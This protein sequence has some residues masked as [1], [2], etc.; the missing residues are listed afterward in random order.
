MSPLKTEEGEI[1]YPVPTAQKPCKTWYKLFGDLNSNIRP[2][3]C[4]HGGPGVSHE[5]ISPM[6]DLA[7]LYHI[8][9]IL[10]DQLGTGRSTHLPEKMG[11]TSFWT[12]QLFLNE[13]DNLLAHFGIQNDYDLLGHSWGGMLG[14]RH[15]TLQPKGLNRLV[16]SSSPASMP[17]WV[18]AQNVL[19]LQLSREVQDTLTRHEREG[20]TES[21][22]YEGAVEVFYARFM[23]RVD[24]MPEEIQASFAGLKKDN[25][26][27]MTMNGPSEFHVTGSLKEWTVV[28]DLHKISVETLIMNGRYD[29]AQDSCVVPFFR[30]IP[31]VKWVTLAESS[32]TGHLEERERYMQLVGGFLMSK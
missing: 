2:L 1:D 7:S 26:V 11:D 3:V 4:L 10:Y 28:D 15:A 16:I 21:A 23:C 22:E 32:H 30:K 27:Y 9:V 24:P 5:Y 19:R 29:E 25:T 18:E 8:P 17:L 12:E 31:K 14:S 13:L 6:S 20:T